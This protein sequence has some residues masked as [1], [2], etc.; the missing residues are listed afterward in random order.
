MYVEFLHEPVLEFGTGSHVDM[1]F[2]IMQYG[3]LDYAHPLAPKEIKVGI[4]GTSHTVAGVQAWLEHCRTEIPAKSSKQPNLFPRFP[5]CDSDMGFHTKLVLD[6]RLQRSIPQRVFDSLNNITD[7]N[8]VVQE[9]VDIFLAEL[10]YLAEKSTADVLICAL[11]MSLV[12]QMDQDH[13]PSETEH[14]DDEQPTNIH[15]NFRHLL[16]ARAMTLRQPIQ[17]VLPTTYDPKQRRMQKIR[18]DRV[19]KLQDEA[20]RAWNFH[21]ALYYK[22]GGTPWRLVRDSSDLTTCYVGI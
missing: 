22:A 7:T 18:T 2:G 14:E 15:L 13:V 16:K 6:D 12:E 19:R 9:A 4:I 21:T 1:R 3:P 20:T 5:G 17:I 8:V 10:Q 11:P